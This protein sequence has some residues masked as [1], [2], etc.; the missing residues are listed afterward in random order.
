[1]LDTHIK[2]RPVRSIFRQ[3]RIWFY[4]E[5]NTIFNIQLLD[6]VEKSIEGVT[7][8]RFDAS[9]TR[10]IR[11]IDARSA[12]YRRGQWD[13]SGHHQNIRPRRRSRPALPR[14]ACASG[15][16]ADISQYRERPLK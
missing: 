12:R 10:L 14:H 15:K 11:R 6:P 13:F 4:G 8:F 2:N 7:L 16:A 9:G 5:R 3:N 1:V